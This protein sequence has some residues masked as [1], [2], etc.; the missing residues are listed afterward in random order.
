MTRVLHTRAASLARGIVSHRYIKL[1]EQVLD[2]AYDRPTVR[3]MPSPADAHDVR[4]QPQVDTTAPATLVT[5]PRRIRPKNQFDTP[6]SDSRP[7]DPTRHTAVGPARSRRKGADSMLTSLKKISY[8]EFIQMMTDSG[9]ELGHRLTRF[10]DSEVLPG[11]VTSLVKN[12]NFHGSE[13]AASYALVSNAFPEE[14]YNR[15]Y[16]ILFSPAVRIDSSC[17]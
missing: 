4:N 8:T 3:I 9:N 6:S 10:P 17:S 16:L 11:T 7:P 1:R 14:P 2:G 15:I 5:P 12:T 13:S